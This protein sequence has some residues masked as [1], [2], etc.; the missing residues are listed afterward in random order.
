MERL[1]Q[2]RQLHFGHQHLGLGGAQAAGY[3]RYVA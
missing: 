3:Q 2:T 1:R